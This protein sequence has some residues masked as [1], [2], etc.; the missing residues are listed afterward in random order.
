MAVVSP[1]G[2]LVL[3][4][5]AVVAVAALLLFS[6]LSDKPTV[7]ANEQMKS[8]EVQAEA[9]AEAPAPVKAAMPEGIAQA[10]CDKYANLPEDVVP[11]QPALDFVIQNYGGDIISFGLFV[12]AA[13]RTVKPF[14]AGQPVAEGARLIWLASFHT[15]GA[16]F[17]DAK[18]LAVIKGKT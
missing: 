5:F 4:A 15:S 18:D 12:Q 3:G 14:T 17:L 13:D 1:K 9:Q 10:I 2:L 8:A 11:C 7:D 16:V 6:V